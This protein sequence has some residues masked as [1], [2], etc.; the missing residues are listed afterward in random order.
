MRGGRGYFNCGSAYWVAAERVYA[1][2]CVE[3]PE[4]RKPIVKRARLPLF[5]GSARGP[6]CP[7]PGARYQAGFFSDAVEVT[8]GR[9]SC[10]IFL[11]GGGSFFPDNSDQKVRVL[12]RYP[13]AELLRLKKSAEECKAW[14]NAAI[15]VSV[16]KGAALLSM[17]HPYYGSQDIDVES[18][19][20]YFPNSGTNWK[21]VQEK[22]SSVDQRMRFVLQSMLV[23][24]EDMDWA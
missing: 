15:L 23:P 10:T 18:Y 21:T 19:E 2:M 9:E 24:L 11:G 3:Q 7:Y 16:G 12:V 13:E 22:L 6:L 5:Q 14:E 8:N 17:L 20:R 4:E 1:D